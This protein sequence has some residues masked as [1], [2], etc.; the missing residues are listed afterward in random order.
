MASGLRN[1]GDKALRP[2]VGYDVLRIYLGV[3]LFVRGALFVSHPD[4]IHALVQQSGDWFMPMLLGHFIAVAHLCGGLLLTIGL[5]TRLA[6]A[7]QIPILVG[8][9]FMVHWRDGLLNPSQSLE[10]AGLVLAMLVVFAVW[11]PGPLSADVR[12]GRT[13]PRPDFDEH[14]DVISGREMP[15]HVPHDAAHGAR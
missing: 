3:A 8:A 2:S 12:L 7:V 1:I 6:A 14:E 5:A 10:L 13:K 15:T 9:V 11:G 4:R